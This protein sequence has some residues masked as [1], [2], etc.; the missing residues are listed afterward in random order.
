[1]ESTETNR[2]SKPV[3]WIFSC[4][5]YFVC[6]LACFFLFCLQNCESLLCFSSFICTAKKIYIRTWCT[7]AIG[8]FNWERVKNWERRK[9]WETYL[10]ERFFFFSFS[11]LMKLSLE[12]KCALKCGNFLIYL[13]LLFFNAKTYIWRK[14]TNKH[15]KKP[16]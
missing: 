10:S 1:M 6:L 7:T 16:L 8:F 15:N 5:I 12:E 11:I 2:S 4:Y 14:Q 13:L 9:N 3:H